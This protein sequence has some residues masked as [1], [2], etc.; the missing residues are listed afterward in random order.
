MKVITW[1][2]KIIQ[3]PHQ[4][5][6]P[7]HH[8]PVIAV[9]IKNVRTLVDKY[10]FYAVEAIGFLRLK[11]KQIKVAACM[12]FHGKSFRHDKPLNIN[13]AVYPLL[14][15]YLTDIKFMINTGYFSIISE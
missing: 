1:Y 7:T 9:F 13:Y 5:G 2:H 14:F 15:I 6:F 4:T 3:W 8:I 12:R 11:F 10:S